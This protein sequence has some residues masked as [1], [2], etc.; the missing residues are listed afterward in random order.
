MNKVRCL[1]IDWLE[2]YC[3]ESITDFPHDAGYFIRKGYEVRER[4]YGTRQYEEMFTVCDKEG[5]G[6]LEIRRKPVSGKQAERNKGIFSE[7]SCHLKLVNRYCYAPNAID[8]L[9]DFL[10]LHGYVIKRI[11]RFDLALDF[12]KFDDNTDPNAFLKRYL[13]GKFTKVNQ[14]AI[15]AHGADRWEGRLWN[16]VSWGAAKSMVSTKMYDKTIELSQVKDKPYIR[17]AWLCSGLVDDMQNL[18]KIGEDGKPYKPHIWRLEFSIRSSAKGWVFIEDCSGKSTQTEQVPHT[19]DTYDTAEKRLF[20]FQMLARHY[21]HFKYYEAGKRKDLCKDRVLFKWGPTDC[22]CKLD[23]LL[24]DRPKDRSLLALKTRLVMYK[25]THFDSV[26]LKAC[27]ILLEQLDAE[28]VRNLVPTYDRG[29]A[30][31]LQ[32]LIARRI[33]NTDES[34]SESVRVIKAMLS[35]ETEIF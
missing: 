29:E 8:L 7:F 14:S 24:T 26:A 22:V 18:T 20:A 35:L 28:S 3:E 25:Q 32:L 12:E 6:F 17:Y 19:I 4:D 5:H 13:D 10:Q 34:F 27:D 31:L 30:K 21:F 2:L 15:S 23:R 33:S 16:S 1:N 9:S 11:F